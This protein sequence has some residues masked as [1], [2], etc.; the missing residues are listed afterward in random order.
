MPTTIGV[1]TGTVITNTPNESMMHPIIRDDQE[2]GDKGKRGNIQ[3]AYE[4]QSSLRNS[5]YDHEKG[6]HEGA[7]NQGIDHGRYHCDFPDYTP[8]LASP[9]LSPEQCEKKRSKCLYQQENQAV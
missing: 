9:K 7:E 2:Y 1:T 6:K 5:R 4:L 3:A 8:K